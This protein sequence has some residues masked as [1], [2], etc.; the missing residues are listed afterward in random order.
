LSV[1]ILFFSPSANLWEHAFPEALVGELLAAQRHPVTMAR[2]RGVLRP[3][4]P[5]A[6]AAGHSA[7]TVLVQQQALCMQCNEKGRL[8]D[9]RLRLQHIEIDDYIQP[10]DSFLLEG[11]ISQA[12]ELRGKLSKA[13]D[14]EQIRINGVSVGQIALYDL[15]LRHKKDDLS[16]SDAVWDEYL[17][18]LRLAGQVTLLSERMLKVE[19]PDR[20]SV[21]NSLYVPHR[22]FCLEAKRVG[23]DQYFMHAGTNL[24]RQHGTLMIGRDF[25]WKY[26]RDL[27]VRY[28]YYK[29]IPLSI[30]A[31]HDVT[32]HFLCLLSA[33]NIFVYSAARSQDYF[34]VRSH[35][36]V[37]PNQKFLVASTSSY[38]ERFAVE[39]V[40]A[41]TPSQVLLF[42][43]ILDWVAHLVD[44]AKQ[45][46]DWFLLIRVHPREFP[47]RRDTVKSE[48]AERMRDLLNDLPDNVKVNWPDDNLSV[49]DLAQEADV[50]LNAW[51]SVGK[52]MAL[53]GLP[54]VIYSPE[55]VLYPTALNRVATTKDE[56]VRAIEAALIEGWS[57][58]LSRKAYRW[59]ALE[60][61]RS[62]VNL[63]ASYSPRRRYS[64]NIIRRI[65]M[66]ITRELFRLPEERWD[67]MWRKQMPK[68]QEVI[69]RLFEQG[70][71]NSEQ[72]NPQQQ[73]FNGTEAEELVAIRN[74]L[75]RIGDNLFSANPIDQPSKLQREFIAARITNLKQIK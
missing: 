36:G 73:Q 25:T 53:L 34:N 30:E 31:V 16:F 37:R 63:L 3:L 4:C 33:S 32:D 68:A 26:L 12:E 51:S 57:F 47:N 60:F 46:P 58:E 6:Q 61:C 49:Y 66:R 50:F 40:D 22:A 55:I 13:V 74:S 48:H 24:A 54:V 59:F 35:F 39:S 41:A 62:R 71:E 64:K 7:A 20:V 56:Y 2:C 28:D 23:I 11:L 8:L 70:L 19:Q 18:F 69:C 14:F 17:V 9:K 10:Q 5:A 42:P 29:D 65:V 1:S 15:I 38:D 75:Q 44:L 52:E 43:R 72:A 21:Y 67:L 45:H 27:V